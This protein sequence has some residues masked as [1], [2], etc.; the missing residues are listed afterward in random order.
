M[1]SLLKGTDYVLQSQQRQQYISMSSE[2]STTNV[3]PVGAEAVWAE[4]EKGQ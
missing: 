1:Q 4:A 3:L 2:G